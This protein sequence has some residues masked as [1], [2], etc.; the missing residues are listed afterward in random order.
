MQGPDDWFDMN[1][2]QS[3]N[4]LDPKGSVFDK[5]NS[6]MGAFV[7][8]IFSKIYLVIAIPSMYAA[9]LVFKILQEKGI[10]DAFLDTVKSAT[11][12]INA[13][14]TNCFPLILNFREML[15][16]FLKVSG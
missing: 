8:A 15:D 10:I 5:I 1:K 11:V 12:S 13:T 7:R 3:G 9:F 14:L 4:F 2:S 6:G 16:C